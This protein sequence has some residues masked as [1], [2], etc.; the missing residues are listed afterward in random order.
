MFR[1]QVQS[2]LNYLPDPSMF[3]KETHLF[4]G[5][6]QVLLDEGQSD[7]NKSLAGDP[8]PHSAAVVVILLEHR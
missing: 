8:I 7:G 6:G 4:V 1:V 5:V 2:L 3:I